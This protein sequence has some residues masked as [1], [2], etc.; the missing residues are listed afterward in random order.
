[1][2][3]KVI[4]C[5]IF[6]I[7]CHSSAM[8][9]DQL[10]NNEMDEIACQSGLY[11]HVDDEKNMFE[12]YFSLPES[13]VK[14]LTNR[15]NSKTLRAF[16]PKPESMDQAALLEIT[17]LAYHSLV[18]KGETDENG[19]NI[20]GTLAFEI[21]PYTHY[22]KVKV[23][24]MFFDF[25]IANQINFQLVQDSGEFVI[26]NQNVTNGKMLLNTLSSSIPGTSLG[27]VDL[28]GFSVDI[29]SPNELYLIYKTD[30]AFY[31]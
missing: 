14:F 29:I 25:F 2:S 18:T 12:V 20:T 16:E 23:A 1:M 3:I 30:K 27:Q 8:A 5:L 6:I 11:L 15:V 21:P 24:D 31:R 10:S 22:Y 13:P 7:Y 28:T 19:L 9:L 4:R 17:G 26:E